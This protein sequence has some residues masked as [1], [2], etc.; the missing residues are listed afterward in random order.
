M[1]KEYKDVQI[2]PNWTKEEFI[3]KIEDLITC[4]FFEKHR[5]KLVSGMPDIVLRYID[6]KRYNPVEDDSVI[7]H[8]LGSS[9]GKNFTDEEKLGCLKSFGVLKRNALREFTLKNTFNKFGL[10][11]YIPKDFD[12]KNEKM[13]MELSD[14]LYT[15]NKYLT[16]RTH[17]S[18]LILDEL[19]IGNLL[20]LDG[21]NNSVFVEDPDSERNYY[22]ERN[23]TGITVANDRSEYPIMRVIKAYAKAKEFIEFLSEKN[24]TDFEK[25]ILIHD[26]V[27]N[28]YYREGKERFNADDCRSFIGSMTSDEVVCVGYAQKMK[29]LC[30][31]AGIECKIVYGYSETDK[32]GGGHEYNI[33]NLKDKDYKINST[34]LCDACWDAK[35]PKNDRRSYLYAL[36]PL[37]DVPYDKHR[38]Y[39]E[40]DLQ[41]KY[42]GINSQVIP[43]ATF[44]KGIQNAYGKLGNEKKYFFPNTCF[45]SKDKKAINDD[46]VYTVELAHRIM[47]KE[48]HNSFSRGKITYRYAPQEDNPKGKTT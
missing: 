10:D 28:N 32:S 38:D 39:W 45:P 15:I 30:D 36:M 47:G 19:T 14:V 20:M 16:T 4:L 46:L 41:Q 37:Q 2:D 24:L 13:C 25:Y 42:G 29:F 11:L 1:G 18:D 40:E 44:V 6:R 34:Y 27:A 17:F 43:L 23:S 7:F 22:F 35:K 48:A 12:I 3:S 26:Y 33:V 8:S 31:M 5:D 21:N 9:R